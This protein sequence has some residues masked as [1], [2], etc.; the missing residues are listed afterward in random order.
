MTFPE[1]NRTRRGHQFF[2]TKVERE[3]LAPIDA[4]AQMQGKDILIGAH[5]FTSGCDWWA[6]EYDPEN[7]HIFGYACLGDPQN[8][9]WGTSSLVE[10]EEVVIRGLWVVERDLHWKPTLFRDV[11]HASCIQ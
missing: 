7:G 2:P 3:S 6:A 4:T 10:L 1:V 9:E 11:K 5:W 8:A